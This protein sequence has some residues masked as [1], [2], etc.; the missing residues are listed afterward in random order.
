MNIDCIEIVHYVAIDNELIKI[1]ND[2]I[3]KSKA[4]GELER[5]KV[6]N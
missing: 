4:L 3:K 1:E 6:L 2:T 5:E